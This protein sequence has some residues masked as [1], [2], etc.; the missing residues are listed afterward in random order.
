MS[1]EFW[2]TAL[3]VSITPGT[4]VVLTVAAGLTHGSRAGVI[5]A[6]G[7]TLGVVPHMLAAVTGIALL[8]SASPVAFA[9]LKWA[10][11]GYLLYMA[12]SML[13]AGRVSID[14]SAAPSA[15]RAI[16]KAVLA[17][18]LNPKLTIFFF[19]FLPQFVNAHDP[20]AGRAMLVLGLLFMVVT[21]V[22]F[23]GYAVAAAAVRDKVISRPRVLTALQR[24]FAVSFVAL[25]ARL[26]LA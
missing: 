7:C 18:L 24:V 9:A 5:T 4:G 3:I 26:A 15:R 11:V 8:L 20:G 23:A 19:A 10:G 21:F 22:V 25:G 13:R 2:L 17:N 14:E 16:V 6:V 12:I 1:I